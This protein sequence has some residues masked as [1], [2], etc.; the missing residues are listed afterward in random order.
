MAGRKTHATRGDPER[1]GPIRTGGGTGGGSSLGGGGRTPPAGVI[2]RAVELAYGV[3]DDHIVQGR[4]AADA[5]REG[6]YSSKDFDDDLR[7]C[8]DRALR[9]SK[10]WGVWGVDFF[11][12]VRR[13]AGSQTGSGPSAPDVALEVKSK[14]RAEVKFHLRPGMSRFNPS[15]PPIH[16]ADKKK[17]ALEDVR[18]EFRDNS[19]PVLVVNIPDDHP[20]GVYHGAI[21]DSK[22][23]EP[24]GFISVRVLEEDDR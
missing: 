5:L 2:D 23:H 21:V 24:G 17:P 14:R 13:K 15:V 7:A 19:R 18:F 4:R 11:D 6:T 12:V 3:V 9:M 8:L 1:T 20:H 10:E 22:T 16:S